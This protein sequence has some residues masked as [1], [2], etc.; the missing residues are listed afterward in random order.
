MTTRQ[1]DLI[2][3]MVEAGRTRHSSDCAFVGRLSRE[4]VPEVFNLLESYLSDIKRIKNPSIWQHYLL[5]LGKRGRQRVAFIALKVALES[6]CEDNI[7]LCSCGGL[8]GRAVEDQASADAL[9][10][11][12]R[13]VGRSA[14]KF[15]K[16][17]LIYSQRLAGYITKRVSKGKGSVWDE[18]G[19]RARISCGVT[20][21]GFVQKAT[22]AIETYSRKKSARARPSKFLRLTSQTEKWKEGYQKYREK[23]LPLFLPMVVPPEN[24]TG[25][26]SGGY[27]RSSQLPLVPFV[28]THRRRWL[29]SADF[30]EEVFNAVNTI[31]GTPF[32][33]NRQVFDVF[34]WA[35][36]S[37][38]GI[39]G[40][41]IGETLPLP[42]RRGEL[43]PEQLRELSIERRLVHIENRR[44]KAK[45]MKLSRLFSLVEKFVDDDCI[46]FPHSCDFRGRIYPIPSPLFGPQGSDISRGLLQF[47]RSKEIGQETKWLNIH[48]ANSWGKGEDKKSF[49]KR[50]QWVAEN[51]H[52]I[53]KVAQDPKSNLFW[54][55]ADDP[56]QFLA[57]CFELAG[58]HR[59]GSKFQTSLPCGMDA[60][61]SGI[62]ILSLLAR[63]PECAAASNVTP[64]PTPRDIYMDVCSLVVE[65]LRN[66][67]SKG[68]TYSYHWLHYGIDRTT[69]KRSVMTFAYGLTKY[70]NRQFILEWFENQQ[71]PSPFT[72]NETPKATAYLADLV[73]EAMLSVVVAPSGVMD[74]M[75]ELIR[76]QDTGIEWRT[77][78]GF[79]V[80]QEQTKRELRQI[81]THFMGNLS[82]VAFNE[83]TNDI[84]PRSMSNSVVPNFVHSLDACAMMMTVNKCGLKDVMMI[85]DC[86]STHSSSCEALGKAVRESYCELFSENLLALFNDSLNIPDVEGLPQLGDLDVSKLMESDYFVS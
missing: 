85:H 78:I 23:L 25:V 39:G 38:A 18:W 17:Y 26:Y 12:E 7:T 59:T 70:S 69:T 62:Q 51:T 55:E 29:K 86:F 10:L 48:C 45:H 13:E 71:A 9:I 42:D 22:G 1:D 63:D 40:L 56:W 5:S 60:T 49:D 24:W 41:E 20:L 68:K 16:R 46:Y 21:L 77:P 80:F 44:I 6:A 74:W 14:V 81:K 50:I 11:Q 2:S 54:T 35:K 19:Q 58:L 66:D 37:G 8:I 79:P 36:R 15:A 43:T 83:D 57:S 75:Q 61:N 3:E 33:V 76:S 67:V 32:R 84:C 82:Y 52:Q 53:R 65:R 31:Q 73:W 27:P 34:K 4:G 64:S 47:S 28:R 72:K 30:S